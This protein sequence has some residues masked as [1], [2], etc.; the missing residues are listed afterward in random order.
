MISFPILEFISA[1]YQQIEGR[2]H[3]NCQPLNV[4]KKLGIGLVTCGGCSLAGVLLQFNVS[5]TCALKTIDQFFDAVFV[6]EVGKIHFPDT[7]Q[8]LQF[9]SDLYLAKKPFH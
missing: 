4:D 6:S 9:T 8:E 1:S 5:H 2:M 3:S 7:L